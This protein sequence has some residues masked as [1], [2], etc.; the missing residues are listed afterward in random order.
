M[1]SAKR[2]KQYKLGREE[3]PKQINCNCALRAHCKILNKNP[4]ESLEMSH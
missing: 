2:L 4:M 1:V 3:S